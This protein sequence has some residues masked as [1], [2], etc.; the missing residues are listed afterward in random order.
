[1]QQASQN[2]DG[3]KISELARSI[4]GCQS[5][6]DK[7]FDELEKVT[8]EFEAQNAVFDRELKALESDP[9]N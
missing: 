3:N 9:I 4:H 2:Q 8:N 1:M 5:K 6:I 7:L